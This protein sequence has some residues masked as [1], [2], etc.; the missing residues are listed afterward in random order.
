[1]NCRECDNYSPFNEEI[2]TVAQFNADLNERVK[3][4]EEM[5][6]EYSDGNA[7]VIGG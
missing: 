4:Y 7:L 2:L 5:I 3:L 6:S 1:M